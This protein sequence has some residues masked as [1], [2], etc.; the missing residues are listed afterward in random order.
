MNER[1]PIVSLVVVPRARSARSLRGARRVGYKLLFPELGR[2]RAGIN[3]AP[4]RAPI[5]A[6]RAAEAGVE[7]N[8]FAGASRALGRRGKRRHRTD[9]GTDGRAQLRIFIGVGAGDLSVAIN[10]AA[11]Q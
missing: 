5:S 8:G 9:I 6:H 2:E 10:Y 7:G 1:P 11:L 3:W 4:T